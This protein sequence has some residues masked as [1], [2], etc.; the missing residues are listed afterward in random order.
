L[1]AQ[2]LSYLGGLLHGDL[3]TSVTNSRPVSYQLGQYFPA[4]LELALAAILI[5]VVWTVPL[6]VVSAI[7]PDGVLDRLS[8]YLVRFGVAMPSFWLGLLL[9]YVC[10]YVL[11]VSPAPTGELDIGL[12][13]PPRVTG[14]TVVD[15]LLAGDSADFSSA[16]SH[17]VL[18]A[19]TLSLTSC[20]PILSLTRATMGRVLGSPYIRTARAAGLPSRWIYGRYAAKNA[21]TPVAT[22]VAMTLGYLLGGTVLVETVFSW[23]GIGQYAV[24]SMQRLDYAPVL[25]IVLLASLVYLGIYFLVDVF[26]I[27]VDPRIGDAR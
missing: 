24:Q 3:G 16:L 21:A 12:V 7:R 19:V 8:R 1:P 2:Y 11:K 27:A 4:T 6:G 26:S 15:S 23:P 5:G 22:M 9:V 17:L 10:Y 20:P 18:P 25:G 13:P 14:M